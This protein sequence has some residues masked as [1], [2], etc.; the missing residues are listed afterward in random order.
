MRAPKEAPELRFKLAKHANKHARACTFGLQAGVHHCLDTHD[1]STGNQK[2]R[3]VLFSLL[4]VLSKMQHCLHHNC[5]PSMYPCL[6][7]QGWSCQIH[8]AIAANLQKKQKQAAQILKAA[9]L[10]LQN[11]SSLRDTSTSFHSS[12]TS[13]APS[14]GPSSGDPSL[15]LISPKLPH[16]QILI[17]EGEAPL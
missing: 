4:Y 14:K 11:F 2:M 7:L 8:Y 17:Q 16:S 6:Y 10:E 9:R 1:F 15:S 12:K 3:F 13:D 5:K